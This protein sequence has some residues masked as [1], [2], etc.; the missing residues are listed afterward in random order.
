MGALSITRADRLIGYEPGVSPAA[1]VRACGVFPSPDVG[2]VGVGNSTR[3]AV[4]LY[5][6]SLGQV[7]DEFVAVVHEAPGIDGF[8]VS[9]TDGLV[10][11]RLDGDGLDPVKGI[12]ENEEIPVSQREQQLV[13][14]ERIAGRTSQIE[15][16]G[17]IVAK[18]TAN[19]ERPGLAPL[20]KGVP[21]GAI[22][23]AAVIDP[24]IVGWRSDHKID[25][26][27]FKFSHA[28]QAITMVELEGGRDR[29]GRSVSVVSCRW[30][31]GRG[32]HGFCE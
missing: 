29:F 20:K 13:G 7:E 26:F 23:V 10:F 21:G 24:Q 28:A 5:R 9:R 31:A 2:F 22:V 18:H 27:A 8:E 11:P 14:Q 30:E 19:F 1:P 25:A 4:K 32:K 17:A 6:A 15:K 16:E 12:L 3:A